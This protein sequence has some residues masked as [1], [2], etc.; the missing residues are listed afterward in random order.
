VRPPHGAE[1]RHIPEAAGLAGVIERITRDLEAASDDPSYGVR[2]V[3][4]PSARD[5]QRLSRDL[6]VNALSGIAAAL[7]AHALG[8]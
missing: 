8:A 6:V 4:D 7:G 5:R 2:V 1:G 3:V